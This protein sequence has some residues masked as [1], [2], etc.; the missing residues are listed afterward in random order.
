MWRVLTLN[1][2]YAVAWQWTRPYSFARSSPSGVEDRH[3][4]KGNFSAVPW[5]KLPSKYRPSLRRLS[6][7]YFLLSWE[8]IT[9]AELVETETQVQNFYTVT[10]GFLTCKRRLDA[11]SLRPGYSNIRKRKHE[12][13][14]V[15]YCPLN[16]PFLKWYSRSSTTYLMLRCP[17]YL[18]WVLCCLYILR[19]SGPLRRE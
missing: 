18:N 10:G 8:R 13:T 9:V 5:W 1:T 3:R 16:W 19:W 14:K 11:S 15:V 4:S 2:V 12:G 17:L 7:S 6:R